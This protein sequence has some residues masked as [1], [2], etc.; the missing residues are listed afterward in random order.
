MIIVG[1]KGFA[2]E[3]LEI[4]YQQEQD[5]TQQLVFYD[6][7]TVNGPTLLY[8]SY[9][10]LNNVEAAKTYLNKEDKRFVLGIGNPYIRFKLSNK[11]KEMGGRL[12]STISNRASIGKHE[13]CIDP[14]CN[15][16]EHTVISNDVTIGEGVIVYYNSLVTH[17]VTIGNY[18]EL[19]PG[20]VLLGRCQIGDFTHIGSGATILQD[21]KVG[22]GVVVAAGAVV[23]KDVPDFCMVAGVPATIKKKYKPFE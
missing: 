4:I 7:V 8:D 14:G 17:D 3:V 1:A 15:I 5:E 18:V 13:V 16:F 23:T 10:I 6:D 11:F 21:I 9:T 19:S 2:K 20:A 12:V 22:K